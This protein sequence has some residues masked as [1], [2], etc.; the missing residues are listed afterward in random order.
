MNFAGMA[1]STY[2]NLFMILQK[3]E[4]NLH[5]NAIFRLFLQSLS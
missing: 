1:G 4:Q 3:V 2:K 5:R